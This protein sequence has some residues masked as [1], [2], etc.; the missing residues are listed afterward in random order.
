MENVSLMRQLRDMVGSRIFTVCFIKRTNGERRVMN[1]SV[2]YQS[3]TKG[4]E[5][6]YS[7]EEKNLLIVRDLKKN[8]IRSISIDSIEWIH[9]NGTTYSLYDGL[10]GETIS[11]VNEEDIVG[12]M[13]E[14]PAVKS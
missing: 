7:P 10:I 4:G 11:L 8:A 9:A 2:N 14:L 1:C 13:V 12:K 6:A 5:L 3:L